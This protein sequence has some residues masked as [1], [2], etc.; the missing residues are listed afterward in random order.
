LWQVRANS[1]IVQKTTKSDED[2]QPEDG[3]E[4]EEAE[5]QALKRI[6]RLPSAPQMIFDGVSLPR[7]PNLPRFTRQELGAPPDLSVVGILSI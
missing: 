2:K 6:Q 3:R 4:A 1:E 5:G 7:I